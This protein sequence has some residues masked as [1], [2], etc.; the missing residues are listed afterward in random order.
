MRYNQPQLIATWI[1]GAESAPRAEARP[2]RWSV[3]QTV[4]EGI[5]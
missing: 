4:A 3:S 5:G 1:F 2:K